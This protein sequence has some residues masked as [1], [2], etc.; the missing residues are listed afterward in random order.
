MSD[1][2]QDFLEDKNNKS[3]E[4]KKK[5]TL[6]EAK[7]ELNTLIDIDTSELKKNIDGIVDVLSTLTSINFN[8]PVSLKRTEKILQK[9][10]I[11]ALKLDGQIKK[12]FKKVIPKENLDSKK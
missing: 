7:D 3:K 8:D 11:D 2:I 1:N 5:L 12:T 6:E 9:T 10:K 4:M